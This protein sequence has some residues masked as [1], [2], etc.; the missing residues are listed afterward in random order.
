MAIWHANC[1]S[2]SMSGDGD[3]VVYTCASGVT[4]MF[5]KPGVDAAKARHERMRAAFIS[6]AESHDLDFDRRW[7]R[8]WRERRGWA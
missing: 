7:R 6:S 3:K 2:Y 5:R 4:V 8:V 1:G